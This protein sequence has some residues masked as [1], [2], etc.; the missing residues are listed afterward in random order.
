M[1]ITRG[2]AT[3][4]AVKL[5][6]RDDALVVNVLRGIGYKAVDGDTWAGPFRNTFRAARADA[7]EHNARPKRFPPVGG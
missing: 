3:V 5:R 7:L 1:G 4:R 2:K 6:V